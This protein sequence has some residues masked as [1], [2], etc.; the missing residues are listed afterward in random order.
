MQRSVDEQD[1][2]FSVSE[3]DIKFLYYS[4]D[5]SIGDEFYPI[6]LFINDELTLI[7]S[8]FDVKKPTKIFIH[9]YR[10]HYNKSASRLIRDGKKLLL[11]KYKLQFLLKVL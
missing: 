1:S 3:G 4:K 11:E 2:T 8:D 7:N 10:S 6:Q 9:G 5:R